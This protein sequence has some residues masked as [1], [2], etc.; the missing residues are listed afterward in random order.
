MLRSQSHFGARR[1]DVAGAAHPGAAG[2]HPLGVAALCPV[3]ALKK[4]VFLL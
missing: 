2:E 3:P 1:V 4:F